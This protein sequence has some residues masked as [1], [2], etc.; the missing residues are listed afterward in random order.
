MLWDCHF[1]SLRYHSKTSMNCFFL[2]HHFMGRFV[3][4]VNLPSSNLSMQ[5]L[6][7]TEWLP[8]TFSLKGSILWF[9][10]A[11]PNCWP[12]YSWVFGPF[13]SKIIV[14]WTQVLWPLDSWAVT[15][16]WGASASRRKLGKGMIH[17]LGRME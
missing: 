6:F 15:N 11:C 14:I 4:T 12:R 10:L 3:L 7:L 8:C 9:L 13:V 17:E 16:G 1:C 5:S 2:L